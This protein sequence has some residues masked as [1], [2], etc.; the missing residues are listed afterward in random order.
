MRI[1]YKCIYQ[2]QLNDCAQSTQSQ[3]E[4]VL[5]QDMSWR[6]IPVLK[7]PYFI[8]NEIDEEKQ[9]DI[10]DYFRES[11]SDS[12]AVALKEL[13]ENDYS[14]EEIRIMRIKFLSDFGN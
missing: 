9:D 14:E 12:V 3:K 2:W 10:I 1:L 7:G 11:V 8:Q 6:K 13:G 4:H 5:P